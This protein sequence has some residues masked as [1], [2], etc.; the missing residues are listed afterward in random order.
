VTTPAISPSNVFDG[1]SFEPPT[2][3]SGTSSSAEPSFASGDRG[4]SQM[5]HSELTATPT[6]LE[7]LTG[8]PT[9]VA[10]PTARCP[11][12]FGVSYVRDGNPSATAGERAHSLQRISPPHQEVASFVYRQKISTSSGSS[13]VPQPPPGRQ[14]SPS[15]TQYSEIRGLLHEM[16]IPFDPSKISITHQDGSDTSAANEDVTVSRR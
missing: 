6:R 14:L 3:V 13:F 9:M 7:G 12:L 16:S 1:S 10:S 15:E 8:N 4:T 5:I 11:M 2:P